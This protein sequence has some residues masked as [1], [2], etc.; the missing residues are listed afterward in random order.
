LKNCRQFYID[1]NWVNPVTDRDFTVVNPAT[2]EPVAIISLG[3]AA[4]VDRAVAAAKKGL[5]ILF[6]DD[7]LISGW[8]F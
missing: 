8:P 4:D 1:G 6:G 3:S 5:R 7:D 2:E